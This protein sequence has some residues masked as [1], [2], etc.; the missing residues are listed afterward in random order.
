MTAEWIALVI[1]RWLNFTAVAGLF[2]MSLFPLYVPEA[3]RRAYLARPEGRALLIAV[4]VLSFVSTLA[5]AG[6]ALI[7]MAGEC[8][9]LWD[10]DAWS[11]FLF[12]TSFGYAWIV[13][14]TLAV[15][16]MLIV[17]VTQGRGAFV[18]IAALAAGLLISQ[19]W[20]GHVASLAAPTRWG[21]TFAYAFHIL[22]AGAWFGGLLSLAVTM[23][24]LR[25][26]TESD[27]KIAEDVLANFSSVGFV[28]VFVILIGGVTNVMA[29][30]AFSFAVLIASG[31][32]RALFI[33]VALVGAMLALA[34]LNRFILMPR[35]SEGEGPAFPALCRS[36]LLEQI[37]AIA[38]LAVTATLGVLNPS[39]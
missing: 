1:A 37:I 25:R 36:L 10:R 20:V 28:A 3:G 2:G 26:L 38:V 8:S 27:R 19:A 18:I 22:G 35:F 9:A 6:A 5:W 17:G 15:L 7:N 4:G 21:V 34:C 33:K 32:G 13:R 23:T 24:A 14:G 39:G 30:G 12:E 31:W 16:A 29:H 11:S